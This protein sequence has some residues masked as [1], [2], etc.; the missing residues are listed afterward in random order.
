[1]TNWIYHELVN[2]IREKFD[3]PEL[4]IKYR[5]IMELHRPVD[6]LKPDLSL[7]AIQRE[8]NAV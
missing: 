2:I 1:M 6:Y 7:R 3:L 4:E 8:D 5:N